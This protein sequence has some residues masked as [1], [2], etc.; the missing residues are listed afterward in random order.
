MICLVLPDVMACRTF[1][2]ETARW[3]APPK[4]SLTA[5]SVYVSFTAEQAKIRPKRF[6]QSLIAVAPEF[7]R[8][9][10]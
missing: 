10:F 5:F 7:L 6:A 4:V 9:R 3:F 1:P 8:F 2:A